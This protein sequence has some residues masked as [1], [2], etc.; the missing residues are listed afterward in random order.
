[1][2]F[3]RKT[4]PTPDNVGLRLKILHAIGIPIYAIKTNLSEIHWKA[5]IRI[6][7]KSIQGIMPDGHS[8]AACMSSV[9]V[10]LTKIFQDTSVAEQAPSTKKVKFQ[11]IF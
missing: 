10:C 4:I 1:V 6:Y 5:T 11:T 8:S 3:R 9:V 2:A 7:E